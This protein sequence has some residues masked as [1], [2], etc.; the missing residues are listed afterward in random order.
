MGPGSYKKTV[1]LNLKDI[2][3]SVSRGEL[4]EA[5]KA[6]FNPAVVRSV[7]FVPVK[8]VQVTFEDSKMKEHVEWFE[9]ID[10]NGV[11]CPI[12]SG[13]PSAQNI[14]IYH[15]PYEEENARLQAFLSPFGKILSIKYQH[16]P[17][18][19]D[20]STGTRI[21]RT[22]RE[23]AIPRNLNIGSHRVKGWYVGQPTECDI[24]RGA[25]V[26][27]DC[28][29]RG[30]CRKCCQEGHLAKECP[31]PPQPQ[32]V[33]PAPTL[34]PNPNPAPPHSP[35]PTP[36][37]DPS[38]GAENPVVV[39]TEMVDLATVN[40]DSMMAD[41]QASSLPPLPSPS[42]GS[43]WGSMDDL[44]DNE[45]SPM[46]GKSTDKNVFVCS[47]NAVKNV[48]S[49]ASKEN[50]E[51]KQS[52]EGKESN[53]STV[54][55]KSNESNEME[56]DEVK[57]K[58]VESNE[59][60]NMDDLEDAS[61]SILKDVVVNRCEEGP[62]PLSSGSVSVAVPVSRSGSLIHKRGLA[63]PSEGSA[64]IKKVAKESS[65]KARNSPSSKASSS[66]TPLGSAKHVGLPSSVSAVPSHGR[67]R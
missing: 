10:L 32:G 52:N 54:S 67:P 22:V 51:S 13:G 63:D 56:S 55:N 62:P 30:K 60:E 18:M 21:V 5:I 23:R 9:V 3:P 1:I 28:P 45:L 11:K 58:E 27:K 7:Q 46:D 15:F 50:D 12:V 43:S 19:P 6:K 31:N 4:A 59:V 42:S 40:E 53:E 44:R 16:Y 26:A 24:C 65:R 2:T 36:P 64:R 20:V 35:T 61:Q 17:D 33:A 39:S 8:R 57:S 34:V 14:L 41:D 38:S 66:S 49:T 25:H 48:K 47:G 37:E 29:I